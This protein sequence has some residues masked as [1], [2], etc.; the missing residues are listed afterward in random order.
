MHDLCNFKC[1]FRLRFWNIRLLTQIACFI[2]IFYEKNATNDL[3]FKY[4]ENLV[5]IFI[6]SCYNTYIDDNNIFLHGI[7]T[8]TL[9]CPFWQAL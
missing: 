6:C 7:I 4:A 2:P 9:M 8:A 3:V 1:Y 5:G